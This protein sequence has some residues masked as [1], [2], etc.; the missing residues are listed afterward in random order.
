MVLR[1][2][3]ISVALGIAILF[4]LSGTA[5]AQWLRYKTPGIP[6]TADGKP[7]LSAPAPRTADGKP[8]LSG[9][10][11]ADPAGDA[12][13]SKAMASLKALPWAEELSQKRQ[14]DLGKDDTDVLCLPP[15]PR[16]STGVGKIV[17]T[18][19][20]LVMLFTGTLYREVFL[21]GRP[22]PE[23]PN[24]DWM[25]Y[26]IGHWDGDALVIEST[27][28]NDR[29]WLDAAGHPHTEALHVTDRVR[30]RDFGH[31][32]VLRTLVDP[33][34]F[35]GAWTIPLQL[36]LDADTEPL[37]YVCNENERDRSHLVG[38]ASDEKTIHVA[39]AILSKYVGT[40]ELKWPGSN[41]RTLVLEISVSGDQLFIS[42]G[43]IVKTALRASSETEFS[44]P[45]GNFRFV[46]ND[47][48]F[49][50][51]ILQAVEGEIK[52]IRKS[53]TAPSSLTK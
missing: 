11:A 41:T 1:A 45:F 10:W 26:S 14:E 4:T 3:R 12:E 16:V 9:V 32:E 46:R 19:N 34:T 29:T 39:P 15:G 7:D 5:G 33:K 50:D 52:G 24:P 22:L 23:D 40:Y 30:R 53:E 42:G 8:D 49:T 48:G 51:M 20:L 47:Q 27:G 17:Q 36:K 2:P 38:K 31:L 28:F 25:G 6:R 18:P 35:T 43:P 21:D 44:A 13:Y 37:E